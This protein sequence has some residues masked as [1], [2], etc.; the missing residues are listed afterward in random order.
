M[1]KQNSGI[2]K[3]KA[4]IIFFDSDEKWRQVVGIILFQHFTEVTICCSHDDAWAV[5]DHGIT[6]GSPHDII[7][8]DASIRRNKDEGRE[9]LEKL[10]KL[11]NKVLHLGNDPSKKIPSMN[12]RKFNEIK[13]V[14]KI[15]GLIKK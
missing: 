14:A 11:E 12:K 6:V 10:F 4:R 7:V 13:L 9:F 3:R 8:G 5:F 1:I 2:K 15:V